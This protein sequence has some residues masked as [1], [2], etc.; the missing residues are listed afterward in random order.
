[1]LMIRRAR[2]ARREDVMAASDDK[3]ELVTVFETTD[4]ALVPLACAALEQAGIEYG[5]RPAEGQIPVAFGHAAAFV[6][7]D[8]AVELVVRASEA[9][10]ARD[11]LADLDRVGDGAPG[12][13]APPVAP[14]GGAGAGG[15]RT[16]RLTNAATGAELGHITTAQLQFL[17]DEL[18]EE[19]ADDRDYYID[20]A[21][22]DLLATAGADV[23]LVALL[24]QAVAGQE[25]IEIAWSE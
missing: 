5:F 20:G 23:D 24:R 1:M 15:A 17:I 3:G 9:D 18:E 11:V 14:S 2:S 8:G 7:A 12:V 19:S 10:R 21:T 13:P 6:D 4:Q 22:I 16:V 25:G